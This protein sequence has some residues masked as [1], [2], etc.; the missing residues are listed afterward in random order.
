MPG[1]QTRLNQSAWLNAHPSV[2]CRLLQSGNSWPDASSYSPTVVFDSLI[3]HNHPLPTTG[4]NRRNSSLK[5]KGSAATF[6]QIADLANYVDGGLGKSS[7]PTHTTDGGQTDPAYH[8][9]QID[10]CSLFFL[11][12]FTEYCVWMSWNFS[13]NILINLFYYFDSTFL[14]IE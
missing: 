11:W 9:A 14:C 2:E 13:A 12:A 5:R 8:L 10:L 6:N 1:H 3:I 4:Q 7:S